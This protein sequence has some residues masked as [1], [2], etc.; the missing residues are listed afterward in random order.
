MSTP[1]SHSSSIPGASP[2]VCLESY[3]QDTR[4]RS[5]TRDAFGV[6]WSP[7]R[8]GQKSI[9]ND[10]FKI[11]SIL[12]NNIVWSGYRYQEIRFIYFHGTKCSTIAWPW[13]F[14]VESCVWLCHGFSGSNP[15][16]ETTNVILSFSLAP[17]VTLWFPPSRYSSWPRYQILY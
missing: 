1:H 9:L 4:W 15:V 17:N 7:Y 6:F 8:L 12:Y 11:V 14:K 13:I 10:H 3:N 2:S 16:S 5:L